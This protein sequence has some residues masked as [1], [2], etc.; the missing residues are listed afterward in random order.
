MITT[1][2][3]PLAVPVTVT[4]VLTNP[5]T[6]SLNTAMKTTVPLIVGSAWPTAWSI[7]TVAIDATGAWSP[8]LEVQGFG[9]RFIDANGATPGTS[10][11]GVNQISR[12]ITFSVTKTALGGTPAPGWGFTVTLTGQDGFSSDQARTLT[13]TPGA[14]N[15]GVCA[16]GGSSAVRRLAFSRQPPRN[17][18]VSLEAVCVG[19]LR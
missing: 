13:S 11:I 16:A 8:V 2:L 6:A 7:V 5:D 1:V 18:A 14:F 4:S 3:V 19:A 9:Q 12:Y 10:T 17:S 15:F